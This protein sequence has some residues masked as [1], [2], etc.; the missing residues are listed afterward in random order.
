MV[1]IERKKGLNK[2][3][4]TH[5]KKLFWTI[6]VLLILL[7]IV[8]YLLFTQKSKNNTVGQECK[9]DSD[10]TA[11]TC[12]HANSCSPLDKKPDCNEIFCSQICSGPLDCGAGHCGCLNGKC[13]VIKS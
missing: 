13:S 9:T 3:K 5:N 6:I 11:S 12:C 10:C 4:I 7:I 2:V 8:F 1:K